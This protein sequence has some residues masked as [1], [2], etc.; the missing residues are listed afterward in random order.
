MRILVV[1]AGALGGYFGG[2]LLQAGRDV[3]FLLRPRR[4]A[5]LSKTGLN[6]KSPLGDLHLASVPYLLSEGLHAPFD[7]IIV[8]N[9]AYDLAQSMETFAPAVGPETVILPLLN[10]MQHIEQLA[11]RF[12]KQHVLGGLCMISAAL[13]AEGTIL[14]VND[15]HLLAFGELDGARTAR[16]QK[17]QAELSVPTF[18]ARA[19]EEILLEMWE[20][21]VFIASLAGITCLI[22]AAVGDIVQAGVADLSVAL[23]NECAEIASR[24][25]FSPRPSAINKSRAILTTA[26]SLLTASMLK[27]IERNAPVEADHIIGDL[28]NRGGGDKQD[29]PILRLAWAQLKSYEA[30]RERE[31]KKV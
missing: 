30:R 21:W 23:L 1:G 4:T 6:I 24:N 27:D 12:G 18:N 16:L 10:G 22:R 25:D 15:T 13:D 17:I 29:W 14:H 2:R 28:L 3:T 19:S 8:A 31:A 7:V 9:K 26:G 11:A 5:T 20:K